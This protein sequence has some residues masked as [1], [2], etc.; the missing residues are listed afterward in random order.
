MTDLDTVRLLIQD[1]EPHSTGVE[2]EPD[3]YWFTDEQINRVFALKNND[4]LL[5]AA[6]CLR[7][8]AADVAKVAKGQSGG[9]FSSSKDA[10]HRA[11]LESA[12]QYEEESCILPASAVVE[13]RVYPWLPFNR[14]YGTQTPLR[15]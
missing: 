12:K 10:I 13:H 15:S 11:L 3:E 7:I 14:Y 8:L 4:L 2:G 5:T 6:S 1:T 9:Q